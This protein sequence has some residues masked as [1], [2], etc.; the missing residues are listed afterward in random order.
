MILRGLRGHH[1][2]EGN[3]KPSRL[4]YRRQSHRK[5]SSESGSQKLCLDCIYPFTIDLASNV[6]SVVGKSIGYG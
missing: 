3:S 6:L 2:E 4:I 1:Y 5:I